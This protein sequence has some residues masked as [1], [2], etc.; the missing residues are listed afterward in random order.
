M[1]GTHK[2]RAKAKE[3]M[4]M[5]KRYDE[6]SRE[7]KNSINKHVFYLRCIQENIH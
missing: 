1:R 5:R 3:Q 7:N 4:R 2:R 6:C